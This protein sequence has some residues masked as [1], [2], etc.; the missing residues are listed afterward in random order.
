MYNDGWIKFGN[1]T[2]ATKEEKGYKNLF[3]FLYKGSNVI[4]ISVDLVLWVNTHFKKKGTS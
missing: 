3:K 4:F 1:V 2:A